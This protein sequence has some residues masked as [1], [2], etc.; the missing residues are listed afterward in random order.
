VTTHE[1]GECL[2]AWE[3]AMESYRGIGAKVERARAAGIVCDS[4]EDPFAL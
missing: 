3:A 4:G 1:V 2:E